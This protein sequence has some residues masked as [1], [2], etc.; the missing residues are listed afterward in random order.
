LKVTQF[1]DE[2]QNRGASIETIKS[3][4]E[5]GLDKGL[6]QGI[7]APNNTEAIS[8]EPNEIEGL[9][10]ELSNGKVSLA[11]L[12]EQLN[13]S[14]YQVRTVLQ[15]LIKTNRIDGELTYSAFITKATV[16]KAALEKAKEHK[17][18]HRLKMRN[19]R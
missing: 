6:I 9:I 15:Y 3:T 17:R 2:A 10:T 19:K 8:F 16:K 12:A 14:V 11:N 5:N 18:N 4:F 7:I 13:L 1:K